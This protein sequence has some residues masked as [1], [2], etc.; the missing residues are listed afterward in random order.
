MANIFYHVSKVPINIG[1]C[2]MCGRYGKRIWSNEFDAFHKYKE[3]VFERVRQEIASHAPSRL[4]SVFLFDEYNAACAYRM[5]H[6]DY[7]AYIYAVELKEGGKCFAVDHI[8]LNLRDEEVRRI[9]NY[10]TNEDKIKISELLFTERAAKYWSQKEA[11]GTL[12]KEVLVEGN[13]IVREQLLEPF[14]I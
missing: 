4:N 13:V 12:T 11:T 2:L 5:K 9:N 6:Y 14:Y 7:R 1:D 3:T 8:W 10:V